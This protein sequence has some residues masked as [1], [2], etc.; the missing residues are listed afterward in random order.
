MQK[1]LFEN[2]L[3]FEAGYT[4]LEDAKPEYRDKA[5]KVDSGKNFLRRCMFFFL[6]QAVE[7]S[8]R[9]FLP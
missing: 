2:N 8:T 7:K 9:R 4:R 1:Y 6:N 3:A 5:E